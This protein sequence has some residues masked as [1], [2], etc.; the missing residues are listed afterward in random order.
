MLG[1]VGAA[2]ISYGQ[3]LTAPAYAD[4]QVRPVEW[5]RGHGGRL[6]NPLGGFVAVGAHRPRPRPDPCS[7]AAAGHPAYVVGGPGL[8]TALINVDLL[9]KRT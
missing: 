3:A 9:D 1:L 2:G 6:G 8:L 4:V 7:A 5:I